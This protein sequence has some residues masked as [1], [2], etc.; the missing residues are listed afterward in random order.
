[1]K[2]GHVGVLIGLRMPPE[3]VVMIDA[4]LTLGVVVSDVVKV[5]LRQGDMQQARDQETDR[6]PSRGPVA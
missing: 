3:Q 6:Q 1:M 4:G 5:G 2:H